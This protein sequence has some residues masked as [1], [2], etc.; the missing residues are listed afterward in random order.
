MLSQNLEKLGESSNTK[1]NEKDI[2][3]V[4]DPLIKAKEYEKAM[5]DTMFI[6]LGQ[7]ENSVEKEIALR[8][9]INEDYCRLQRKVKVLEVYNS[10]VDQSLS[11]IEKDLCLLAQYGRRESIEILGIPSNITDDQLEIK[12]IEI[13]KFLNINVEPFDIVAVHR[14]KNKNKNSKLPAN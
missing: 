9:K 13:L 12:A 3:N 10:S 11:A 2:N 4:E 7:L 1:S 8:D 6:R 14:L 5:I